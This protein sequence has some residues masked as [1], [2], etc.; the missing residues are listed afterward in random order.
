MEISIIGLIIKTQ[1]GFLYLTSC[2]PPLHVIIGN[3]HFTLQ[4]YLY[5][6]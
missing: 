2:F 4:V 3:H 5:L 1:L 6:V